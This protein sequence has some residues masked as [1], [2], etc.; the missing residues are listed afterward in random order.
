MSLRAAH[1]GMTIHYGDQVEQS[2]KERERFSIADIAL[3]EIEED[4]RD[5]FSVLMRHVLGTGDEYGDEG[6]GQQRR[7]DRNCVCTCTCTAIRIHASS[8]RAAEI[9]QDKTPCAPRRSTL[10][11]ERCDDMT[12]FN[13]LG[14]SSLNE[15][16]DQQ[17]LSQASCRRMKKICTVYTAAREEKNLERPCG[18]SVEYALYTLRKREF[19]AWFCLAKITLNVFLAGFKSLNTPRVTFKGLDSSVKLETRGG[20]SSLQLGAGCPNITQRNI[21]ARE[22]GEYS[23]A[24]RLF[25]TMISVSLLELGLLLLV[26]S[27]G[28]DAKF[29]K[30]SV[31]HRSPHN[32][33]SSSSSGGGGSTYARATHTHV[34]YSTPSPDRYVPA[35]LRVVYVERVCYAPASR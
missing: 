17:C 23:G 30:S 20:G 1:K 3:H 14:S 21:N 28:R 29:G 10:S 33:S 7:I 24:G 4:T 25:S 32:G 22:H 31:A 18:N 8:P 26:S 35:A 34:E 12:R 15:L 6:R 9:H 13:N 11:R 2:E 27:G 16:K 19:R 5:P